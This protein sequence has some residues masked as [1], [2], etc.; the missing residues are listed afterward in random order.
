MAYFADLSPC[1]YFGEVPAAKLVAVGWL[2]PGFSYSMGDVDEPFFKQLVKLLHDPW[3]PCAFAGFHT[4]GLCRFVNAPCRFDY[5]NS[6]LQLGTRNLFVPAQNCFFV[7]PSLVV[8]YI[9]AHGYAPPESFRHA[10]MQCPE[11]R[12]MAY[13]RALAK[14]GLS[15]CSPPASNDSSC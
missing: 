11:M 2:E 9:S 8:H 15:S 4:C 6:S 7:A 1:T 12:S 3:E 14:L 10:V 13:L 5:D